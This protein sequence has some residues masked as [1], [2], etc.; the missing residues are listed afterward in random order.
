MTTVDRPLRIVRTYHLRGG[1]LSGRHLDA[2]ERLAARYDF[3][4]GQPVDVLEIGSGMGDATAQMAAADPQRQYLAVEVHTAGVAN[5]LHLIH[6]R[7]LTNVRVAEVDAFELLAMHIPANSLHAVHVFFP[8]PWPKTRHHKRRLIVPERVAVLRE[9]M[10]SG[11]VLHCATDDEGYA[12]AML[13]TLNAD[14]HLR[15]LFDGFAPRPAHRP[16]TKFEQRAVR[17]GR[18]AYDVM[19]EKR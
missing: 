16:V 2:L 15:N 4:P 3:V 10:R 6:E 12:H 5:L 11:G 18:K 19:F 13:E 7:G 8:D 14:S 9:R 17:A 1:R